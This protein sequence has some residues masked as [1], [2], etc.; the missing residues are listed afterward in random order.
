MSFL[1]LIL[2]LTAVVLL[3]IYLLRRHRQRWLEQPPPPE[4]A[5]VW[6]G[7]T[8]DTAVVQPRL[9]AVRRDYVSGLRGLRADPSFQ[10]ELVHR[11]RRTVSRLAYFQR[12]RS[13]EER[14]PQ[15]QAVCS[16][17]RP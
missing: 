1:E 8:L 16:Y 14:P 9:E 17:R 12:E 10:E 5:S 13:E 7:R 15:D 4:D 6:N 3:V 11:A 2:R